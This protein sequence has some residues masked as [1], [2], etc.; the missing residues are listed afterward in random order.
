MNKTGREP[1]HVYPGPGLVLLIDFL[2]E[3]HKAGY[4]KNIIVKTR[5]DK[6]VFRPTR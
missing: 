1:T 4:K 6:K 5:K 3:Y 2:H